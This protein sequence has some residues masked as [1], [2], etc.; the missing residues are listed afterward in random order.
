MIVD[1]DLLLAYGATYK[2]IFKGN[3]I[4][5]EGDACLFYYQLIAG[6]VSW[7]NINDDGKEFIQMLIEPGECFGELPLFDNEPYGES[8]IADEDSV[9]IRLYKPVFNQLIRE[10]VAIHFNFSKLLAQRIRFGFMLLHSFACHDPA[11]RIKTLLNYL[12]KENKNFCNESNQLKLT[13]QK[14]ADMTGL[15]VET[16]IRAMRHMHEE[17]LVL[18][19]NGKVFC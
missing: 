18:I 12:K 9:V 19:E 15:R 14:I 17:G 6:R 7:L 16:V 4:F 3:I 10:N 1:I 2:K 8:A 13:R 11:K 5:T